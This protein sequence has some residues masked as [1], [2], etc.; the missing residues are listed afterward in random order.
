MIPTNC[1]RWPSFEMPV[2]GQLWFT[3][4]R[5]SQIDDCHLPVRE[6]RRAQNSAYR[7]LRPT[8]RPFDRDFTSTVKSLFCFH[9]FKFIHRHSDSLL[10]VLLSKSSLSRSY[11]G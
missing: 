8:P 11:Q 4:Q 9:S 2:S 1:L 6:D 10:S 3:T 5:A 7:L